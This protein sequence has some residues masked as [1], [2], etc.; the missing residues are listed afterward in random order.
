MSTNPS[1]TKVLNNHKPPDCDKSGGNDL[2]ASDSAYTPSLGRTMG[3]NSRIQTNC[4]VPLCGTSPTPPQLFSLPPLYP[5]SPLYLGTPLSP[6]ASTASISW[7]D[8]T[9]VPKEWPSLADTSE[10]GVQG[11]GEEGG[12]GGLPKVEDRKSVV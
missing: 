7:K 8:D 3:R 4:A 5:E 10:N 6:T 12:V 2:D 11:P 1:S 9:A